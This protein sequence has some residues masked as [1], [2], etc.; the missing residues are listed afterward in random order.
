MMSFSNSKVSSRGYPPKM[1]EIQKRF[2]LSQT[3]TENEP[4]STQHIGG[5]NSQLKITDEEL[6]ELYP[7]DDVFVNVCAKL[8]ENAY[9]VRDQISKNLGM[10][11]PIPIAQ[12]SPKFV[13]Y[14]KEIPYTNIQSRKSSSFN[15]SSSQLSPIRTQKPLSLSSTEES[16][17]IKII[18]QSSTNQSEQSQQETN[19]SELSQMKD[20]N[21][22]A[23]QE[24]ISSSNPSNSNTKSSSHLSQQN[25]IQKYL[26]STTESTSMQEKQNLEEN[27]K[28]QN[29]T[30]NNDEL[31]TQHKTDELEEVL[32][33]RQ[34]DS[35]ENIEESKTENI[36]EQK[37]KDK[38]LYHQQTIQNTPFIPPSKFQ[39][40]KKGPTPF[41]YPLGRYA[42]RNIYKDMAPIGFS[43]FTQ[44]TQK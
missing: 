44:P 31:D 12:N 30:Q 21:N 24:N 11:I 18:S 2:F 25:T 3:D 42:Q 1:N 38:Q 35:D 43:Q 28:S 8:K 39:E 22:N 5:K 4:I 29:K 17:S 10:K 36:Q 6:N 26:S 27:Q 20:D 41:R 13:S 9:S 33:E 23:K 7:L 40:D 37:E 19:T 14:S 34:M 32:E 16:E 15:S